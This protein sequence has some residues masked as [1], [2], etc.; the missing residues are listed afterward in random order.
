MARRVRA[1]LANESLL[2]VLTVGLVACGPG[3][4]SGPGTQGGG[5]YAGNGNGGSGGGAVC[6]GV[7]E[8]GTRAFGAAVPLSADAASVVVGALFL[9]GGPAGA[10]VLE[11]N[12]PDLVFSRA[13]LGGA[14]L[15]L[16]SAILPVATALPVT[17]YPAVDRSSALILYWT[18]AGGT[19]QP[20]ASWIDSTAVLTGPVALGAAG[21][22]TAAWP[23]AVALPRGAGAVLLGYSPAGQIAW[24]SFTTAG[25]TPATE[26][27]TG[28]PADV[29]QPAL[30]TLWD[31]GTGRL[32]AIVPESYGNGASRALVALQGQGAAFGAP[33][34]LDALEP[35]AVQSYALALGPTGDPAVLMVLAQGGNVELAGLR[36][37]A[38]GTQG[39]LIAPL[40]APVPSLAPPSML[41][42]QSCRRSRTLGSGAGEGC[43]P[44]FRFAA[45]GDLLALWTAAQGLELSRLPVGSAGWTTPE[46]LVGGALLSN[47]AVSASGDAAAVAQSPNGPA[48]L[49]WPA[50]GAPTLAP[51]PPGQAASTLAFLGLDA[52]G[53]GAFFGTLPGG[54][55]LTSWGYGTGGPGAS[56]STA[57][58][59]GESPLDLRLAGPALSS[60]SGASFFAAAQPGLVAI[61]GQIQGL[62]PHDLLLGG[63]GIAGSV[64]TLTSAAASGWQSTAHGVHSAYLRSDPQGEGLVLSIQDVPAQGAQVGAYVSFATPAGVPSAAC[65]PLPQAAS[66]GAPV[67]A[68]DQLGYGPAALQGEG[69]ILLLVD[70]PAT[71]ALAR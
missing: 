31:D 28:V 67:W 6:G 22:A 33:I 20:A 58:P 65:L 38:S 27:G 40:L 51:W 50:N 16:D 14:R 49:L 47:V 69:R 1:A 42:A 29:Q 46:I 9:P 70:K 45:N 21:F 36:I 59:G 44:A 71:A 34:R 63:Y 3:L 26:V 68:V 54:P 60:S 48:L 7:W 53:G 2:L 35:G 52:A 32:V 25:L 11:P 64:G 55:A 15:Q 39:G 43:D 12:V 61:L 24:S 37:A 4:R 41:P 13:D 30:P 10:V 17:I 56:A 18:R 5:P 57:L 62:A 19:T 23:A 8:G 66:A